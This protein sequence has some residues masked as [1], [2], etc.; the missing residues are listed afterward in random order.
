M[1]ESKLQFMKKFLKE[2][3]KKS[4]IE[5]S[6]AFCSLRIMLAAKSGGDIRF[7]VNYRRLNEFT[8]KDTYSISLIKKTLAQLKNAK[9]FTKINIRQTFHKLKMAANLKDLTTFASRFGTFKWKMLPFRLT[10][11]PVSWQ[12]FIND[13]LWEYLNKFYTAYLDNLLIY[14]NNL[15]EHKNHVRL[16]LIKLRELGIQADVDKCKFY[17]T[18]TKYLGL[19]IS[20]ERIKIDPTK[21]K[22]IRQWDTP[23]CVQEVCLFVGFCNFYR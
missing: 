21:I 6:S 20:T 15:K 5:A 19:I 11:G 23:T 4:F 3:L 8:K 18:K 14:S 9:V 2:H 17:V 12:Q 16:V 1:S 10:E 7:C 22:A 13:V